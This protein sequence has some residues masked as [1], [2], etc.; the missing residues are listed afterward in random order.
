MGGVRER[1]QVVRQRGDAGQVTYDKADRI[2]AW[3]QANGI[4]MRGHCLYWEVESNVQSWLQALSTDD[5]LAAVQSRMESAVTHFKGKFL[6][7]DINNEMVP[8]HYYKDR[9]GNA[10]RVWM[11]QRAHEIDPNCVLF[12]NEYNV[13]EGGY[14]LDACM[15]LVQ[16]LLDS[17][18]PVQA[19][20][21][22]CHFSSGFNARPSSTASTS[23]PRWACPS[24]ARNSMW[25]TR[26]STCG[27]TNWRTSTASHSAIRPC[28]AF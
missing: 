8:G 14:S 22:Q 26:T 9:L 12:V 27:P 2:Y 11:F 1:I 24:G 17:G 7:W 16:E 18:A 13:I 10:I 6:H 3:C 15:Q 28:R 25:R 21:V 20:G 19:I 4:T 5:L 23:W